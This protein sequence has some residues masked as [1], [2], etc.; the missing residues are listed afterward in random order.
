M[1]RFLFI[2]LLCLITPAYG[3]FFAPQQKPMLGLQVN[4]AH[5]LAP[6]AGW[7][8]NE[9]SGGQVYDLSGNGNTGNFIADTHFVP[10]KY[11]SAVDVDGT[12]DY[13]N[14]GNNTVLDMSQFT[15]IVCI[16]PD[17]IQ[18]EAL[19]GIVAKGDSASAKDYNFFLDGAGNVLDFRWG[20][21]IDSGLI[22]PFNLT[23]DVWQTIAVAVDSTDAHFYLNGIWDETTSLG[24]NIP[25]SNTDPLLIGSGRAGSWR[26]SGQISHIVIYNRALSASEIALLYRE[27]FC[28]MEPSWNWFLYGGIAAPGVSIP[29]FMYHYMNH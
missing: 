11:G 4:K 10:G 27:P 25:A 21:G 15:I 28:Y 17:S 24:G 3:Q 19:G 16:K 5:P 7:L 1:K 14:C 8:F 29:I 2:F 26:W 13:I 12:D 20:N 22:T 6:T 23:A 18:P 9:G